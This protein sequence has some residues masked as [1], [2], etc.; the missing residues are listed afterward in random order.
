MEV[1]GGADVFIHDGL[2]YMV[3]SG[4][5][6]TSHHYGI[7]IAYAENLLGPWTKS[8][9]NPILQKEHGLVGMGHCMVYED[10]HG[11][12][13]MAYHVHFDED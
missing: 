11:K 10:K 8:N 5:A 1:N 13:H 6:Y 3:F 12:L 2:Y 4:N 9:H 7:G